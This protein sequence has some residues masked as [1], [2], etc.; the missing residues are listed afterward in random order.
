M[1]MIKIPHDNANKIIQLYSPS[2]AV[3]DLLKEQKS[4]ALSPK[5]LIE[6]TYKASLFTDTIIFIA[7]A[8]PIRE[9][10]WWAI[11]C[12]KIITDWNEDEANALHAARAWVYCCDEDSR[13]NA[14][15]MAEK[16]GLATGAGWA[17]QAAFWSGGSMLKP[18]QPQVPPSPYLYA[19]AVAGCINLCAVLPDG[20]QAKERYQ[21]FV[22]FG[23]N[24]GEGGNG[25]IEK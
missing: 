22:D 5:K 8:L 20:A 23:I 6:L 13:R 7:H 15:K 1:T 3:L 19:Q 4:D 25:T 12:A 16:A 17:A 18:D 10:V 9:S 21:Q 2:K 24:I 11:C 14:E